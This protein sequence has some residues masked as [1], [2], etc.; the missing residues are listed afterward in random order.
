MGVLD[1]VKASRVEEGEGWL[2][3]KEGVKADYDVSFVF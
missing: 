2:V 1:T 3:T